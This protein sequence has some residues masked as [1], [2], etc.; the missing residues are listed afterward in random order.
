MMVGW[1]CTIWGPA[2]TIRPITGRAATIRTTTGISRPTGTPHGTTRRRA[3][4]AGAPRFTDPTAAP[5]LAPATTLALE[6]T[7]AAPPRTVRMA[8]AAWRKPT[9]L[10]R[11]RTPRHDRDRTSMEI[12]DR[13]PSSGVT[14]GRKPIGTRTGRPG[15]P[16]ARSGPTKAGRSPAADRMAA[17]WPL[18]AAAT[19]R[20]PRGNVYRRDDDTWQKYD[21]GGWSNTDRQPS[22]DRPQPTTGERSGTTDS[23]TRSDQLNRDSGARTEGSQRTRDYGN[24]RGGGG[25]A[26][27]GPAATA[28]GRL[29]RRRRPKALNNLF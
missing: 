9:T 11:A 29:P 19:L 10:A 23:S 15:T 22:G 18:A 25:T 4:M 20:R 21:N 13:P 5:A 14:T 8:L 6:P 2:G 1:G 7:L 28:A 24:Y 26:P 3:R 12:G 27:A 16:P 17:S